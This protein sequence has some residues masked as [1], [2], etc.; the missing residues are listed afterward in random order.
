MK[1][2]YRMTLQYEGTK[3]NG[4]QKQGNTE[5]DSLSAD[6]HA[7]LNERIAKAMTERAVERLAEA[8]KFLKDETVSEEYYGEWA[9]KN[10][11]I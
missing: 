2:N 8:F 11:K 6:Y 3:Y 4:W 1:Q 5:T 7:G 10:P 9:A